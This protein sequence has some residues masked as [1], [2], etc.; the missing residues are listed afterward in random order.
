MRGAE[1]ESDGMI[2]AAGS[3]SRMIMLE[4]NDSVAQAPSLKDKLKG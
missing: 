4:T 3:V 1:Q 2:G